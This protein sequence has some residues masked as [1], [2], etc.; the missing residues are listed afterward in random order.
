MPFQPAALT[1]L[2]LSASYCAL[3]TNATPENSD[4]KVS[5]QW[6]SNISLAALGE[7]EVPDARLNAQFYAT[8]FLGE[9]VLP[10]LS[11]LMLGVESL[12]KLA[13]KDHTAYSPGTYLLFGGCPDVAIAILPAPENRDIGVLNEVAVRCILFGMHHV[14]KYQEFRNATISCF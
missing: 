5:K 6:T 1:I 14:A 10:Y 3:C 13:W 2:I 12:A 8:I 11:L 9:V 4:D 7:G